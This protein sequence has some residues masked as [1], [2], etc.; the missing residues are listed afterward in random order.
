MPL[1]FEDLRI[2]QMAEAIADATWKAV[3]SWEPFAKEVIGKQLVRACDSIGANIAEAFGRFHY[4]EKLTFFYYARGSLFET[5]YWLNRAVARDLISDEL[6]RGSIGQ[7]AELARQINA[8]TAS[9]KHQRTAPSTDR[10]LREPAELYDSPG[11]GPD[12]LFS[13]QELTWLSDY[14]P[15]TNY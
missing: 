7:L 14:S 1:A 10:A 4:G 11:P 6:L 13:E 12:N 9:T 2:L 5:K 8:L 3:I 15:I